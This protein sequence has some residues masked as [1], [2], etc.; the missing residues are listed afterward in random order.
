MINAHNVEIA[1]DILNKELHYL[2]DKCFPVRRVVMSFCD[3]PWITP[4][5][6]YLLRK[7]KRAADRAA[8]YKLIGESRKNWDRN[9]AQGSSH[10]WRR[11]DK[12]TLRKLKSQPYLENEFLA[13]LNDYSGD[14]CNDENYV[15]PVPPEVNPE[16]HPPLDLQEFDVM[17]ALSKIKKTATGPDGLLFW[18]WRDNCTTLTPVVTA[19]WNKSVLLHTADS[20]E[21]T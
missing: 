3:P 13:G 16:T 8:V 10:W 9:G 5:V 19:L 21:K 6:K 11:V 17:M 18:V 14:L 2:M 15:K 4:L 20:L 7:K 12:I 1:T